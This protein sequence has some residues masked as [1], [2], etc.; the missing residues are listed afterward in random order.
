MKRRSFIALACGLLVPEPPRLKVYSFAPVRPSIVDL[1]IDLQA[2]QLSA[3]WA[4]VGHYVS[5]AELACSMRTHLDGLLSERG[6]VNITTTLR[7][8]G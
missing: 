8:P 1:I 3:M 7:L 6:G 5:A 4:S 2:A